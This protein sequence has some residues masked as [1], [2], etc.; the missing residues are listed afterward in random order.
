MWERTNKKQSKKERKRKKDA[1]TVCD[2]KC[3]NNYADD[4]CNELGSCDEISLPLS[5][6]I[7]INQEVAE[8][9]H[10]DEGC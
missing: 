3:G 7:D 4:P 5:A 9:L 1:C 6:I 2:Y 10:R 8:L